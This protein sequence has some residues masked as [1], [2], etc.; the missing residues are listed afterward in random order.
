MNA[1][2]R[3]TPALFTMITL[4]VFGIACGVPDTEVAQEEAA[5]PIAAAAS[6]SPPATVPTE[7]SGSV[8]VSDAWKAAA[9]SQGIYVG[10]VPDGFP[11][12]F[13]PLFPGGE[14]ERAAL[15]DGEATLLQV[16]P[17]TKEEVLAHYRD[18]YDGL[19]WQ[20]AEPV[21]VAGRTMT[22]FSGGGA[23]VDMTLIDRE[24]GKT[25]VALALH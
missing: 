8:A 18:F 4:L 14:I 25:F 6:S 17:A 10:E 23:Q 3:N 9:N 19:N 7:D 11:L 22:G 13:I 5:A 2:L 12:Q 15:Q 20:L 21:T 1:F 16:V 24:E